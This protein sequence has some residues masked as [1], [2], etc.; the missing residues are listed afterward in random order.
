MSKKYNRDAYESNNSGNDLHGQGANQQDDAAQSNATKHY[1]R[2]AFETSNTG[3]DLH[4][5]GANQQDDAA[6]SNATKHYDRDAFETNNTGEDL[7]D[8]GVNQVNG[9]A[10]QGL[11]TKHYNRDEMETNNTGKD[12]HGKGV[13]QQNSSYIQHSQFSRHRNST[14]PSRKDFVVSF[15]TGALIGS[16]VGLF[17]K[18]KAEEKVD[19]AKAKEEEFRT[20]Y[21][22]IKQQAESSI[23]NVK[24]KI[25]DFRN[26]KDSKISSD[27]LKAQ[28]NAIKT[29]TSDD[30]ADQ[31]PQAQEIQEAKA[32]ATT[33]N[34][35]LRDNQ[36]NSAEEIVAQQNAIKAETS[37]DLA[38]QS[39][40]AQEIQEAKAEATESNN[41]QKDNKE[42]SAE[43]I[44][45]QQN[46]IKAETSDDLAD[47]SPQAQEIQEAKAETVTKNNSQNAKDSKEVSKSELVAQQNAVKTEAAENNLSDP[48]VTNETPDNAKQ[49]SA[50]RLATAAKAK[51]ERLS[52]DKSVASKTK[53]LLAE[54]PIAKSTNKKVPNLVTKETKDINKGEVKSKNNQAHSS[55]KFDNGV[56]THDTKDQAPKTKSQSNNK[57]SNSNKPKTQNKKDAQNNKTA[58]QKQRTE[59]AKSKIDKRTFND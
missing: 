25:E 9:K 35:H 17:Y 29:E 24:Q 56:V 43:E 7:R 20:R 32:E 16:A 44:V 58:K 18:N 39:P 48:S 8:N 50:D 13:N 52:N 34:S 45:A 55:A 21:N 5:Y 59:K 36:E 11:N 3:N 15:I 12:L 38:D 28:Q 6:Q 26:N 30:L 4:G 23:E 57:Q 22:G 14:H 10:R 46:A 54:T 51:H 27:E 2:D 33:N 41:H 42:N 49:L 31:S 40:Q 19:Q 1:D 47:Q 37:S 53:S